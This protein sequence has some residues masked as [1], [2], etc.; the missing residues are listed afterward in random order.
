MIQDKCLTMID[1]FTGSPYPRSVTMWVI[2]RD[3]IITLHYL[4]IKHGHNQNNFSLVTEI[5]KCWILTR[6]GPGMM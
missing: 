3:V 4:I 5:R 6:P 1:I 2:I